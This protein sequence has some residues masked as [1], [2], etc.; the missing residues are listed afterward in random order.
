[1]ETNEQIRIAFQIIQ[2]TGTNLFL[3][4]KAGTGKTTFLKQL[5]EIC[6]KRM[7]V[8][9]PT[10]VAA[11][12]AGGVTIHS[13][14]QLPLGPYIPGT[15]Q[16]DD[17]KKHFRFSKEKIQI[18]RSLDLLVIDEVSMVR[19]DLLDAVSDVLKRFRGNSQP[20]GGVQLLL[21]GDLQQLAPV[22]KDEELELLQE[23]YAS[24]FFF[25]SHELSQT[26]YWQ[27]ELKKVFRQSD[28]EFVDILNKVRENR[29]DD[30]SLEK[31]NSRFIPDFKPD[32]KDGYI[33]LT[34]HNYMAQQI[35]S[36][37]LEQ[38]P[39]KLYEFK[40]EIKDDF[41]SY[42]YPTEE[43]LELKQGAQVMFIKNDSSGDKLYYNGKIG[44][45]VFVNPKMITVVDNDGNEIK[46][47]Q[48]T[49]TNIKYTL[50]PETKEIEE[51]TVGT[52]SQFPLKLAWAITIH[53]SQGL[54]FERAIID[55]ALAF[56]HGQ[57]YVALSRCKTLEG[58]VLSSHLTSKALITDNRI[59]RFTSDIESKTPGK[60]QLEEEQ[61]RYY[62][63]LLLELF[64]FE[65][66][67]RQMQT[68]AYQIYSSLGKL[69]PDFSTHCSNLRDEFRIH[70]LEVGN[71]FQRQL[72]QM[73]NESASYKEDTLLQERI[74]KGCAYFLPRLADYCL[75]LLKMTEYEIDNKEEKKKLHNAYKSLYEE[76]NIKRLVLKASENGFSILE[77]LS[78]KA[79]ASINDNNESEKVKNNSRNKKESVEKLMVTADILNP[80]LFEKIRS[81]RVKIAEAK[82]VP[83]YVILQQK[84]LIGI[85]NFLPSTEKE[86]LSIPGIGKKVLD[87]YGEELLSLV[88]EFKE[89]RENTSGH[90]S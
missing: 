43:V 7:I 12:N 72:T 67:N 9:A 63:Y 22:V 74:N 4:G 54:T 51:K 64:N 90:N 40:A 69:Y 21:I 84:A 56:S 30:A 31:L 6:K 58:L 32:E 47:Q 26:H 78:A 46:V 36:G 77:Y 61:K 19:A 35:N 8:V 39:G 59:N 65:T 52:F 15:T 89:T 2:N 68:S 34:T 45:V 5:K 55:A 16:G 1:M 53:K 28:S 85:T 71:K 25:D 23:H 62:L 82:K 81:W 60:E 3:T 27:I 79:R 33:T 13:F 87:T 75:P 38:L 24:P 49:W 42:N 37:K 10:G 80:Q 41:P 73:V 29:L 11:M 88:K 17:A 76:L 50:N 14:F 48:E 18:I 86:L 83:V 66:L 57:V 44:K 20:F 70:I